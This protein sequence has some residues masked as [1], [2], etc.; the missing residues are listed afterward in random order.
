MNSQVKYVIFDAVVGEYAVTTLKTSNDIKDAA[1]YDTVLEA[2][3]D[4]LC[5]D[6]EEIHTVYVCT[7]GTRIDLDYDKEETNE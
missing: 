5:A 1:L 2:S 4:V 3:R 6:S 7:N